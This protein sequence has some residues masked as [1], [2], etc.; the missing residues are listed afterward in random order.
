M[1]NLVTRMAPARSYKWRCKESV[2]GKE[3]I[4]TSFTDVRTECA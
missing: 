1:N 2:V 4:A 3:F